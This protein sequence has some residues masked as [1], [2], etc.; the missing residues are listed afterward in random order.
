MLSRKNILNRK[1]IW[2]GKKLLVGNLLVK[3]MIVEEEKMIKN[4]VGS[5]EKLV[6]EK[7]VSHKEKLFKRK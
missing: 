5:K 6:R 1:K 2:N 4:T 3:K 7:Y